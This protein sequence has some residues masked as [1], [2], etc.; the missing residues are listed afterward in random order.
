MVPPYEAPRAVRF[1]ETGSRRV[2]A[3][4]SRRREMGSYCLKGRQ[5]VPVS[6]DRKSSGEGQ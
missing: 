2:S 3:R 6:R 1:I 4:D 5:R